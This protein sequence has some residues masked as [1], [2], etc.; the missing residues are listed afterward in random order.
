MEYAVI[1]ERLSH[2]AKTATCAKDGNV[3]YSEYWVGGTK[4]NGGKVHY[5]YDDK[6]L[7][8]EIT[9]LRKTLLPAKGHKY[10]DWTFEPSESGETYSLTHTCTV[11]DEK[12]KNHTETVPD[13]TLESLAV[14]G[15]YK[16]DYVVGDELNTDGMAEFRHGR[17]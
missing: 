14:S 3:A 9:D 8:N 12:E 5:F 7:T 13:A 15:T 10:G 4:A 16:T 2:P 11:C 6:G 17:A 1:C